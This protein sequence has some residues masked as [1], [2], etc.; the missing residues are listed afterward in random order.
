MSK[1]LTH[2]INFLFLL[3]LILTI[4]KSFADDTLTIAKNF[5]HLDRQKNTILINK[6]LPKPTEGDSNTKNYLLLDKLYTFITP[7]TVIRTDSSYNIQSEGVTYTAYFTSLPVVHIDAKQPIVDTPSIYARFLLSET[8]GTVTETN[9]GIEIRGAYSQSYPKKSYEMSLWSDTTGIATNDMSLLSMRTD[10]KWNLQALYNEPLRFR[11]KVSNELWQ[12]IHQVYYKTTEP[13][14][15]NGIDM[16][17]V[18]LFL[19]NEYKGIYALTER[20]DR[21]QL[22]LKKYDKGIKGEL[23][24]GSYWDEGVTFSGAPAIDNNSLI[25]AGFEYKHPDEKTDWTNLYSFVD[26]VAHSS[27]QDFYGQYQQRFQVDNA[28]DYFIFLNLLRATDNTGKNIYVAKYKT[29]EP[30]YYVPWDLDGVFGTNWLGQNENITDDI[31]TNGF[32]RRL[33]QDCSSNGFRSKL[34]RRWSQLRAGVITHEHIMEKFTNNHSYLLN[35]NVYSREKSTWPSFVY[36]P[37]Q[38]SYTAEWLQ[39]RLAYLDVAFSQTCATLTAVKSKNTEMLKLYPNPASGYIF[40]ESV[41]ALSELCIQ[42]MQGKILV[43]AV[44]GSKQNKIAVQHLPKGIYLATIKS[45]TRFKTEK[46]LIN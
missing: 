40:I 3:A 8:N 9:A 21:K 39:A 30:Y 14:A 16:E 46:L 17:Y 26:F 44:L 38:L 15:K 23:Y 24:K 32:Y 22:K 25:W 27:D 43:T 7:P 1:R 6:L 12:E 31:L 35:N 4:T 34:N 36:D 29:N 2:K 20:I 45:N 33:L 42:D 19:N 13:E 11:S 41:P 28:V 18:E 5:Y 10:N 37:I